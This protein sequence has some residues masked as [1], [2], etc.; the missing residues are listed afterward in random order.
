MLDIPKKHVSF[1]QLDSFSFCPFKHHLEYVEK[2][3]HDSIYMQFGKCFDQSIEKRKLGSQNSW[4]GF[5]KEFIK[6]CKQNPDL[7]QEL[8]GQPVDTHVWVKQGF[9]LYSKIFSWLDENFP[10]YEIIAFQFPLYE[11]IEDTEYSF[12]GFIDLVIKDQNG[13]Y[14]IIDF[15][16]TGRDWKLEKR[17]SDATQLQL[18]FYK[19]FFSD[20]QKIDLQ[21]IKTHFII[22]KRQPPDLENQIE[23]LTID[24]G[25]IRITNSI[26][27]MK[28]KLKLIDNGYKMKNKFKCGKCDWRHSK[29]CP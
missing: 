29:E 1:S 4:I 28:V 12:K 3:R 24:V 17:T 15:K 16:T 7:C 13:L 8:T 26:K 5:A 21:N 22:L 19:K 9:Q 14:N 2:R 6:W 18:V 27:E 23:L 25:T 20:K 11:P 10:N